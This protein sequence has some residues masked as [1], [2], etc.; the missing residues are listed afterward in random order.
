MIPK[1]TISVL[2]YI[3]SFTLFPIF[4]SGQINK[5]EAHQ[6]A[7]LK[8]SSNP[9]SLS[10]HAI[11]KSDEQEMVVEFLFSDYDLR[12]QEIRGKKYDILSI[13]GC[14]QLMDAGKPQLPQKGFL[15][16][17]PPLSKAMLEIITDDFSTAPGFTVC[18]A[19]KL[20]QKRNVEYKGDIFVQQKIT[21][22]FY[23]DE[24]TYTT[25]NFFPLQIAE[26]DSPAILRYQTVAS[27]QLCPIQFNPV[28]GEI[29]HHKK[30]V[31]KV[32]F[33]QD[34]P[35][36]S[37]STQ[38]T[39]T[40]SPFDNVLQN[41]IINY[42]PAKHWK[43]IPA[44]SETMYKSDNFQQNEAWYKIFVDR[45]GIYYMDKQKLEQAGI[46]VAAFDP[47][48]LKI[49][50]EGSEIAI[51]VHG[52]NDGV[53]DET[54]YI[55]FYG[56]KCRNDYTFTNIYWLT[57]NEYTPGKRIT[58]SDGTVT[59]TAPI[60]TRAPQT[61]HFEKETY[62]S[63]G[64][65][66]G[67]GVDHW[68]WDFYVAPTSA[69]LSFELHHV[70]DTTADTCSFNIEFHG[71]SD[72]DRSPDHHTIVSLNDI[73]ILD[74]RWDGTT[75]F[76]TSA[77]FLQ[78]LLSNGINKITLNL[79]GDTGASSDIIYLNFFELTFWQNFV[80][81]NDSLLITCFSEGA[82][83]L[84]L[85]GFSS[86]NILIYDITDSSQII[87]I[88]NLTVNWDSSS[89]HVYFENA[90]TPSQQFLAI[91][92]S[93][94]IVPEIIFDEPTNLSQTDRQAD[95]IFITHE[96]F[97]PALLPLLD[98]RESIGLK[99]IIVNITDVY[100]E[101]N[102]GIKNPRAIKDFLSHAFYNW[103]S[104]APTYVTL[105]GDASYDYK[106]YTGT[107]FPDFVP[108]HLF[109]SNY[110]NTETASD[111]W[112]ACV[113]GDDNILDILIGRL[114]VQSLAE[115]EILVSKI[116]TYETMPIENN[117][118]RNV[119]FFADNDDGA[120]HF[121]AFSDTVI[122]RKVPPDYNIETVYLNNFADVNLAKS[123]LI[124][125]FNQGCLVANYFGHGSIEYLA[126]EKLLKTSD[127][128]KFTNE[129]K[130]PFL[131]TLSC[132]NGFFHHA[133]L[134]NCLAEAL[135][136]GENGGTIGCLSPSGFAL[137]SVM[138]NLAE[139]LYDGLFD[140][141]DAIMGSLMLRA[142]LGLKKSGEYFS[143]HI[144][145]Y[146][147]FGDP[148]LRL[149]IDSLSQDVYASYFGELKI[150]DEPAPVG[151][152]LNG[153]IDSLESPVNF[154]VRT[155]GRYG[156]LQIN[157]DDTTTLQ[158]DGAV[159]GDSVRFEV[160]TTAGD[161][162]PVQKPVVWSPSN[163]YIDLFATE[164]TNTAVEEFVYQIRVENRILGIDLFDGDPVFKNSQIE[165]GIIS[166]NFNLNNTNTRFLL[167]GEQ[168]GSESFSFTQSNSEEQFKQIIIFPLRNL[169]DGNYHFRFELQNPATSSFNTVCEFSFQLF[170]SLSLE[171]VLNYP[172]PMKHE[173]IFTY[174]LV[175]E[176]LADVQIK[177]YTVAG[178][179]IKVIN[180]APGEIGFNQV[181]WDGCDENN[182]VIANGVYFYKII[183]RSG[184]NSAERIDKLVIVR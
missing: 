44:Q 122:A 162:I 100:D 152:E 22:E 39:A 79:A 56:V 180:F 136:K 169:A 182:N 74:N 153:W 149:K 34:E 173:T 147:L 82:H 62:Y 61:V 53:F 52:E 21:T 183:A 101:F 117:W 12:Q 87:K 181:L 174:Y 155:A 41:S 166:S 48:N 172:N 133:Q 31:V 57:W 158:I 35:T 71:F 109:E 36:A 98:Y 43:T 128:V 23:L 9:S 163:F 178:R 84:E 42:H 47:R 130:Q 64:I 89:Y 20:V 6:A 40:C 46:D 32:R 5:N 113:A 150:E 54:D 66:N 184:D 73:Q 2:L 175:N 145:F 138:L 58:E 11:L 33:L 77:S 103:Q 81:E 167:N 112:F 170:S 28:T 160:V 19:P 131:V 91:A 127:I 72:D 118:N 26:I 144:S 124:D 146:N 114:A 86:E 154:R 30:I 126:G 24:N 93:K 120:E 8:S 55:E 51:Y 76:N 165:L 65:P 151:T 96:E 139:E 15:L 141:N 106:D 95:Y 94:R 125:K 59:G 7:I 67:E 16:A 134:P 68:F 69:N 18:P 168:T 3:L 4:V 107:G 161:T 92:T 177:I 27:I 29:R 14:S 104:P 85:Q 13:P 60:V 70:A 171:R 123:D 90:L 49:Y 97:Y 102:Y 129:N 132:L 143:D 88:N 142:K 148:A 164:E 111:N 25:N 137:S 78:S 157:G 156:P 176:N 140:K 110:Y 10:N 119:L 80:A 116:I 83:Q 75:R 45:D 115:A 135:L 50:Y 17:I 99:T 159:A 179:L 1:N 38:Q 108:T 105:V 121:A 37:F 63:T